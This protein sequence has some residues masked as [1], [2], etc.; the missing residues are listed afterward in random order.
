[1]SY[2]NQNRKS[3]L[4]AILIISLIGVIFILWM[5]RLID[6]E[7]IT[8][9]RLYNLNNLISSL[10]FKIDEIEIKKWTNNYQN[11]KLIGLV[12]FGTKEENTSFN[13]YLYNLT[14]SEYLKID[15][16]QV[17]VTSK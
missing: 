2:L 5:D 4:N 9:R 8:E 13:S 3:I 11:S 1:M 6:V 17:A 14:P 10:G 7:T 12:S 16:Y 15:S